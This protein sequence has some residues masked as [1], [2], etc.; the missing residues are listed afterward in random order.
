MG[1][2]L[3]LPNITG[4]TEKE[5]LAQIKSYLYQFAQ[6]LQWAMNTIETPSVSQQVVNQTSQKVIVQTKE[7]DAEATFSSLKALIIK[8]ADIVDAYYDEIST[9]LEGM[10]VA[11]SDFGTFMEQTS[12]EIKQTS[13]YTDQ[14]FNDVQVII[15]GEVENLQASV[16]DTATEV[17]N[18]QASVDDTA[19]KVGGLDSAI[20]EANKN[21]DALKAAVIE[22]NAYIRSGLLYYD[23]NEIPVF[24][25]EIGQ[26]NT[27]NDV[28]VFN[29]YARFT[30][31][32]LSFYD[33]N[34]S[35]IAYISD[36]KLYIRNVEITASFKIGGF[37][38]TVSN[39]DVVTKWVGGDG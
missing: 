33:Q 27:V 2:D 11:Q 23:D 39:G 4:T 5:Q 36:Y 37:I 7:E 25:L 16:D 1:L 15:T 32:R 8:S 19:E 34:D 10:Y 6:Q 30:S 26:K 28:D 18:L 29:K 12:Q 14:K 24:G 17:E 13:T 35:E 22:A 38:D 21:I 9:R 3:R 31:D 20:G